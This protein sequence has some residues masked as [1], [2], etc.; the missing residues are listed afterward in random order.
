LAD[1]PVNIAAHPSSRFA[2]VLHAGYGTNEIIVVRILEGEITSCGVLDEAFYGHEWSTA[3]Y[4]T[5]FVEKTWPLNYRHPQRSKSPYPSD[6]S[7]NVAM[8]SGGYLWDRAREAGVSY[9]SC[10]EFVQ[11]GRTPNDPATRHVKALQ[12]HFDP[13]YRSFDLDYPDVNRGRRSMA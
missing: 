3:A 5:D 8:S 1:F 7:F 9:R 11:N 6:G 12:G 2:A 4:A 10:G 13:W